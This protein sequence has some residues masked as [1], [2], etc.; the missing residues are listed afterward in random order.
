MKSNRMIE[1]DS[2]RGLAAL[3]VVIYHYFYRYDD[4]F[5]HNNIG[6]DWISMGKHGVEVFFLVSGFVIYWSLHNVSKPFDF[7]M[8]RISRLYP[9]YW[10]SVILTFSLVAIVGLDGRAVSFNEALI[11]LTMLQGFL[12]VPSVDGVY[13]T[14]MVELIFYFWMFVLLIFKLH[15][16]AEMFFSVFIIINLL[17]ILLPLNINGALSKLMLFDYM[18]FFVSGIC[19][20]KIINNRNR[21]RSF[22][23]LCFCLSSILMT[24]SAFHLFTFLPIFILFYLSLIG[25]I[26]LMKNKYLVFLGGVSYSLYLV[27][28]NIG[29]LI[30]NL[31]YEW[32][33]G[34]LAGIICALIVSLLLAY[35]LTKYIEKPGLMFIRNKYKSMTS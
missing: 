7:V 25:K 31:F 8:S 13:W 2:V 27:H 11:N 20:Y 10:V 12:Q 32:G 15:D 26:S 33:V 1:L 22:F 9:V 14:L 6:V 5:G 29:Y 3:A 19:F 16:N 30:I 4:I 24:Y 28:Q 23:I 35:I 18:A 17:D 34:G 21:E